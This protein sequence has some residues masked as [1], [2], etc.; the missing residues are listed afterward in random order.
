VNI[1]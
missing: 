1:K